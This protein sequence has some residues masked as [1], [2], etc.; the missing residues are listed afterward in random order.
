MRFLL[1]L[2]WRPALSLA[3]GE[4]GRYRP[5]Y[6]RE[7]NGSLSS[8]RQV[9]SGITQGSCLGHLLFSIF[10]NDM[11]LAFRKA[12]MSMRMTQHYTRQL[13]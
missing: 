8:I 11:T 7:V 10:T 9:E 5:T 1:F 4:V 13:L 3:V 12:S 2:I 6:P